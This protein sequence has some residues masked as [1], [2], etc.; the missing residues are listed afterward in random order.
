MEEEHLS[1]DDH[2]LLF[3]DSLLQPQAQELLDPMAGLLSPSAYT[4]ITIPDITQKD[5]E[6]NSQKEIPEAQTDEFY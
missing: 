5:S 1:D 4:Q 6:E 2:K 3:F